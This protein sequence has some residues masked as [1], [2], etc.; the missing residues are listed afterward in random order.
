MG[1]QLQITILGSSIP[2]QV[3]G[4]RLTRLRALNLSLS[5]S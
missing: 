5:S 2:L 1:K 4:S 3:P